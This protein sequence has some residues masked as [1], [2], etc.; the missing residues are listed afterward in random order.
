M[1]P[2]LRL[3]YLVVPQQLVD[4][5][6]AARSTIDH[7]ASSI[8]Q[9]ALAEFLAGGQFARHVRQMR[10]LYRSRHDMLLDP[11]EDESPGLL[12]ID[13]AT[14]GMHAVAWLPEMVNDQEVAAAAADAGIE[15][16]ALSTHCVTRRLPPALVLGFAAVD[17]AAIK[18][19]VPKLARVIERVMRRAEVRTREP[20]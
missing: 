19:A 13:A 18:A 8:E 15:A 16:S 6:N 12:Q 10:A 20:V 14:T 7:A 4:V 2:A 11:A 17:E 5:F 9:L 1:F 3:G